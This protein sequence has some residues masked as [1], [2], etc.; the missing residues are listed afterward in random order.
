MSWSGAMGYTSNFTAQDSTPDMNTPIACH[1]H[2]YIEI[3]CLYGYQLEL[4]MKDGSRIRGRAITTRTQERQEF[5]LLQ[6]KEAECSLA[7][8]DLKRMTALTPHAQFNSI[9]F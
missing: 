8:N 2:D 9:D 6:T 4:E 5:L 7:L 1:L 3:A